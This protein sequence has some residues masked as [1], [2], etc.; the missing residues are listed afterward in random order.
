MASNPTED[1]IRAAIDAANQAFSQL[2]SV[3]ARAATGGDDE[4]RVIPDN[5]VC[6]K[7]GDQ[8]VCRS[9]STYCYWDSDHH[10]THCV[11]LP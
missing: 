3:D 5:V 1:A 8:L 10:L 6:W 4:M 2:Q 11:Y 7:V 9:G